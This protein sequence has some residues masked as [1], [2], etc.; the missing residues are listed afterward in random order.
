MNANLTKPKSQKPKPV[1]RI[2][3]GAKDRLLPKRFVRIL[4]RR[5]FPV[6]S[7]TYVSSVLGI[8]YRE[9]GIGR[10]LLQDQ[11][12]YS[13]ALLPAL[14]V[15]IP[16]ILWIVLR[17]S[18]LYRHVASAWYIFTAAL[19]TFLLAMSYVLLP[20][21][22]YHNARGYLVATIPM[23]VVMYFTFV[24]TAL[25]AG[26]AHGLSVLGLTVLLFGASIRFWA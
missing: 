15:S 17:G 5:Y 10:Y 11:T 24:K 26:M 20:E 21:L 2:E 7:L 4:T 16:A 6:L 9:G 1:V 13:M 23:M 14:W 19:M 3:R 22:D 8:A 25:P 18:H 12:A